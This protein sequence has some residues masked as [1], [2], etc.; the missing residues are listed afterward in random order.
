MNT[1]GFTLV[2]EESLSEVGGVASLWKHDATGAELLSVS[3]ADENK[4]FGVTFRTPSSTSTGVAHILEHSVLCGSEKYPVKE[5]FVELLKG[6]LQTFLNAFTF[7]D[8]TCYPVASAN[9]RDFYNLVDV[10][11]DAVFF[12]RITPEVFQQ[13]GWH[14]ETDDATSPL[15]Y[16]GV[17]FNEMKGVYSS[18]DSVLA[19]N[20]Q[21]AVFPDTIYGLDSGGNPEVIPQLT[22]AA[23]K[24]FH[25]ELYAPGNA[26]FFFWGD[27]PVEERFA[28]LAPYLARFGKSE[29]RSEVPLQPRRDTPMLVEVPFAVGE[30]DEE[31]KGHMTVNWLLCESADTADML[32]LETLEHI[33]QGLP[34]SPLRKALIESGL[35]EDITGG[36]LETDLRQAFYSVGLRSID[37]V[38]ADEV[39]LLIMETLAA[40]AEDGVPVDA[41]EAAL[42]SLEFH[43]RENNTGSFPRGLAA[44]VQS[45]STWLYDGD[46]FISLAWEHPLAELKARLA[47]GEKVFENAIRRWFL[48]NTHRVTV[49]LLPDTHLAAR[50]DAAERAKLDALAAALNPAERQ[51]L[52]EHTVALREAQQ[53]PDSP[54][55]LA[56][57]PGLELGDLP[58]RN[59]LIPTDFEQAGP[60]LALLHPLDTTGVVYASLLLPLEAVPAALMPLVPL[61]CRA[62]TEMG[63]ARRDF[64]ELGTRIAARTGGL[65]AGPSFVTRVAD[66][67]AVGHIHV[68]GKA[69]ADKVPAL[70]ELMAEMLLEPAFDQPERFLQMVLEERARKEQALIPRGHGVVAGRLRARHSVAGWLEECMGGVPALL[71]VRELATRVVN[72][73]PSVLAD[74]N[75][76]HGLIVRSN[77]SLANLTADKATLASVLPHVC[78]LAEALPSQTLAP[79]LWTPT[80]LPPAGEAL[81]VPAQV[82]YVGKGGNIYGEDGNGYTW[83]GS[84]QV[85]TRHMRMSWLWDQVRVQGGAYGA[86]CSID[87]VTGGFAQISYRDPNVLPTLAVYDGSANWLRQLDLTDRDLTRAIV[88]AIGDIDAYQLPD[89]KGSTALYRYLAGDSDETRQRLREETLATTRADFRAFADTLEAAMA[90]SAAVCALGGPAVNSAA[91]QCGWKKLTLL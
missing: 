22:Y 27:D 65:G 24:A 69:T 11:L 35:G 81:L 90:R 59:A 32:V 23:F 53:A 1:H 89:A 83:H 41:I 39:E 15:S 20:S 61:W 86:F 55:A 48:D 36:G 40:L 13:E 43:L 88:G 79:A 44:M 70:F 71:Y 38:R 47:A 33:L 64:V 5:P 54:E 26:R 50:R 31:G 4:C 46:P 75:T 49:V 77:A 37:P 18:S 84:A 62:L 14:V 91:D 82:N 85:I 76:L 2:R 28:Q 3:N 63:T 30:D 8:K 7:P 72:D 68:G 56:T 57:I 10:Y 45:L 6:S 78:R 58:P 12:P 73:W 66:K 17:V 51:E 34:G 52:A 60:T 87:R 67:A 42:N 19:E 29:A 21:N 16:K 25:T 9:L 80:D 74:L